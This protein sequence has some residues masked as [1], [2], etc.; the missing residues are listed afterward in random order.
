M[1]FATGIAAFTL[2]LFAAGY[3]E[4][5]KKEQDDY[6]AR[7]FSKLAAVGLIAGILLAAFGYPNH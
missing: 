1:I 3:S 2:G 4:G 7:S 6:G 5:L